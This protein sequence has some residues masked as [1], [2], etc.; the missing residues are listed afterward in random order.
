MDPKIQSLLVTIYTICLRVLQF[1]GFT[2]HTQSLL[3]LS[4]FLFLNSFTL[5]NIHLDLASMSPIMST[6]NVPIYYVAN[7][8][9]L[10]MQCTH[11]CALLSLCLY[12][13]M[14]TGSLAKVSMFLLK[15]DIL[16]YTNIYICSFPIKN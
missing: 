8:K 12:F 11:E 5:L 3:L 14:F 10:I 16:Q 4:L 6:V 9:W 13:N 15:M 1:G 2:M 7:V